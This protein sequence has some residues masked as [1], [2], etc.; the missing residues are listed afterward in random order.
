MDSATPLRIEPLALPVPSRRLVGARVVQAFTSAARQLSRRPWRS[1]P[2]ARWAA[3]V[4]PVFDDLGGTFTKFGQLIASSPGLFGAEVAAE[5]RGCLDAGPPV[6]FDEIR[7]VVESEL[8]GRIGDLF[9]TFDPKPVAAASLAAV[10]RAALPD[11]TPVAVKVLRPGIEQRIATDLAVI[12]PLFR[13]VGRQ[14]AV[15][16]AGALP[17]LVDGLAVQ[18]AE[19]LDLTNEA[20]AL[21]WAQEVIDLLGV[22]DIVVP[23]PVVERSSRRVLTMSFIEGVPIDDPAAIAALGV[24]PAALVRA[25]VMVWFAGLLATGVFH[26]DIHA[27]NMFVTPGGRL[28]MLD[29][30]IVGRLDPATAKFFRRCLE[31]VLGDEAAWSD[32]AA[33]VEHMYGSQVREPLGLSEEQWVA[34][35]RLQVEPLFVTPF[36]QVD[37]RTMLMGEGT[38]DAARGGGPRPARRRGLGRWRHWRQERRRVLAVLDS[39]GFGGEFDRVTFLLG[40][41]LVYFERYG[42]LFMPDT[43]LLYDPDA[44]RALLRQA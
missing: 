19:E 32:V 24:E 41:Q 17:G 35:V 28:A 8:G 20:R 44:F 10:H 4:R 11:G 38:L 23:Q 29:W 14:V 13:F 7:A 25:C 12:G 15:G 34:F 43:P 31:A 22:T 16:T 6:P 36:G 18:V 1:S 30:G 39:E 26:G 2:S 21:S 9:P 3:V 27:G 33:H 37:L 5:F 40:K 42:K